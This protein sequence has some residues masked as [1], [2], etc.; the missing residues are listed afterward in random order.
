MYTCRE[1]EKPVNQATD[2]CP[3][4]GADLS[5]PQEAQATPPSSIAKRILVWGVLIASMWAFLWFILPERSTGV[6]LRAESSALAA[7]NTVK[8]AL[9]AHLDTSGSYPASLDGLAAA[10]FAQ[11]RG[12]AQAAQAEGYRLDY[13]PGP[14]GAGGNIQTFSLVARPGHY[15]FR[16]FFLNET[17]VIRW[18]TEDRPATAQDPPLSENK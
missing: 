8:R 4:C 12:A 18:T 13:A 5:L 6:A 11:I 15:G 1:C 2:L 10:S 7:V 3:Y 14:A 9:Q 17:G 16:N